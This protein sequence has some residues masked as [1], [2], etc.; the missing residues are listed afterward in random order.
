M[1]AILHVIYDRFVW[2]LTMSNA[3]QGIIWSIFIWSTFR[4][5]W[6][7]TNQAFAKRIYSLE[8]RDTGHN[9][10]VAK[11]NTH[12]RLF[13]AVWLRFDF[14]IE[15]IKYHISFNIWQCDSIITSNRYSKKVFVVFLD[16]VS[17][18]FPFYLFVCLFVCLS[19]RI[20][21]RAKHFDCLLFG[22]VFHSFNSLPLYIVHSV[23]NSSSLS[24]NQNAAFNCILLTELNAE[25]HT[26]SKDK[27]QKAKYS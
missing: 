3:F 27:T 22:F 26:K 16:F 2:N 5:K 20:W 19:S 17:I 4:W 7:W 6:K 14:S 21:S 1:F 12:E 10:I 25:R 18:L 11:K 8:I 24:N 23:V 15:I 9:S 13:F